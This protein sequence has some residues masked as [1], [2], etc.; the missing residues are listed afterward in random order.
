MSVWS[1]RIVGVH[2]P[3]ESDF[4]II[5]SNA[6]HLNHYR[7]PCKYLECTGNFSSN[8]TPLPTVPCLGGESSPPEYS[9]PVYPPQVP[10]PWKGMGLGIL[11]PRK[12][13]GSKKPTHPSPVDR[14]TPLKTGA[15]RI[16]NLRRRPSP[17]TKVLLMKS[18]LENLVICSVP[19]P[20]GRES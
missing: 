15:V 17:L 12:D 18:F 8:F 3:F 5:F 2:F 16:S 14:H 7:Q 1:T 13:M 6:L 19:P 4:C 10:I 9:P 20:P 11:T